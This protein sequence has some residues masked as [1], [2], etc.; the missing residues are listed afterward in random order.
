MRIK[1]VPD[2]HSV[3]D[4]QRAASGSRRE[5]EVPAARADDALVTIVVVPR[6][7][8]SL[9]ERSLASIAANT[10]APHRLVYVVG[11]A[12][13]YVEA[14]LQTACAEHGYDLI[15]HAEPLSPNAARNLGLARVTTRYVAF[16]D[17]DVVVAPG[18]LEALVACAEETGGDIVG[19]LCLI[20][21]PGDGIVHSAGGCLEFV[22]RDGTRELVA[23]HFMNV[24]LKTSPVPPVRE[25]RDFI[26]GHGL[27]VRRAV[28]EHV[29]PWDEELLALFD[30]VDLALYVK[31]L[32]GSV[33]LEP[34]A[35]ISYLAFE[36][37]TVGDL[38]Y[39]ALRWSDDWTDRSVARL[40]E[41]WSIS[42]DTR[43]FTDTMDFARRHQALCRFPR[44]SGRPAAPID[45]DA[46]GF[47]QTNVQLFNQMRALGYPTPDLEAVRAGYDTAILLFAGRFRPSGK[48]FLAHLVG[49]ASVLAAYGAHAPLIT[50]GL[51]HASDTGG[52]FPGEIG[53]DYDAQRRW[54]RTR[55]GTFA[56]AIVHEYR[57]LDRAWIDHVVETD[58]D[59]LPLN[60][61]YAVVLRIA[62]LIEELLDHQSAYY[63]TLEESES[64][65]A[66]HAQWAAVYEAVAARLGAREMLSAAL[67]LATR[68]DPSEVPPELRSSR[69]RDF[70][71]D[72]AV[73][74][75]QPIVPT[76][77]P[78][79][80]PRSTAAAISSTFT[81]PRRL[82]VGRRVL[83]VGPAAF[84]ALNGGAV[85]RDG[86]TL[87]VCCDPQQWSYS[88]SCE[89]GDPVI[90]GRGI[91]RVR[92][93]IEAGELGVAVLAKG[94]ST[95]FAAPEHTHGPT[96]QPIELLFSLA[97]VEECGAIVL[98]S[99]APD[100][101]ITRARLTEVAIHAPASEWPGSRTV[102]FW[103]G[104][105][106]RTRR[107]ALRRRMPHARDS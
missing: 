93:A 78:N 100:G 43:V 84:Y 25:H 76:A 24:D 96:D 52:G 79:P 19:P 74:T 107:Q 6:E 58:I 72:P 66:E 45:A 11:A 35:L 12:P 103:H 46:H 39:F 5:V 83:R 7:R 68:V 98:R 102:G 17:N 53:S 56:E 65:V 54:L 86:D 50:A 14:F 30:Y 9:V 8:F 61:A 57:R 94:S 38:D 104:L 69:T 48:T 75:T 26:E 91:L 49:T 36:D 87:L 21:E 16:L 63:G 28:F 20:G 42:P 59:R 13:T 67:D 105:L 106:S 31:K 18:W 44:T 71:V 3:A 4:S 90:R 70:V 89:L 27:L 29:G 64:R 34:T 32:G 10:T 80:R 15:V 88:A 97:A 47:A 55:V 51:V 99:S 37:F 41:K 33:W 77:R 1:H 73:G 101:V 22:P 2:A 23:R 92:V 82:R 85:T 40:A 60:V 62:N 81:L 95:A